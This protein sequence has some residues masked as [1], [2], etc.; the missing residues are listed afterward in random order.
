VK[1][2]IVIPVINE[3]AEIVRAMSRAWES[4]CDEL[5]VV[6]GGSRDK[7]MELAQAANCLSVQGA[8]GRGSQLNLGASIATGDVLVFL[9]V[10]NWLAAGCCDQLRESIGIVNQ[11]W[12]GFQQEIENARPIYRWLEKGN[13]LRTRFQSLVYGDQAM[14]VT[15]KAFDQVDGFPDIPLMEDFE[16]SKRLYKISFP[17]LLPGP[18]HVGARRWEANGV[19]R[20][21]MRNW[22][23]SAAYRCG[24]PP[25]RLL[26]KYRRHDE[27]QKVDGEN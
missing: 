6:D 21:T 23:L 19:V 26:K 16:I 25:E 3:E 14:F 13:A 2:S 4:G 17:L 27:S 7:T 10:D 24:V 18:V 9:H 22:S 15:R 20:Q 8:T 12:G 11:P 1:I 5:I